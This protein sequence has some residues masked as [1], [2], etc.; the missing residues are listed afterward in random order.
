MEDLKTKYAHTES[1]KVKEMND[2]CLIRHL[3]VTLR[4][5]HEFLKSEGF[6]QADFEAYVATTAPLTLY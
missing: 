3:L 2:L 5:T 6:D 1:S 4:Q